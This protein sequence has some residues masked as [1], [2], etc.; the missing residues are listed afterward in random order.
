MFFLKN[1][2]SVDKDKTFMKIKPDF[3]KRKDE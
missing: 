2:W 3:F 1:Q